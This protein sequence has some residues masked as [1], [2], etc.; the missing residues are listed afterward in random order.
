MANL[1]PCYLQISNSLCT[2][3]WYAGKG[4]RFYHGGWKTASSRKKV[5]QPIESRVGWCGRCVVKCCSTSS[6]TSAAEATEQVFLEDRSS[7][8]EKEEQ[9]EYLASE[10]GWKVRRLAENRDE[11]SEVAQIQAEAFHTPV[12]LFD[13]VFFE[14]FKAEVLSGLLY[15]LRNSS[16]RQVKP[17][18]QELII[19]DGE[20]LLRRD[21]KPE[22]VKSIFGI[23]ACLVAE[24]AAE[25]KLVGIVDVTALRDEDVLQHLEGADEYLYISGI[26]VSNNFR[27]RKIG[28]ALLKACDTLSHLWGFECLALRAYEDDMGARKLYTNAGYRVVSSDPRWMAWIGRKRRVLMIKRSNMLD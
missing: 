18:N 17:L 13:D 16:P 15:K 25:R 8:D 2:E 21:F 9:F 4:S 22:N 1:R 19:C 7:V 28:S 6:P 26:A 10:S 3:P 23:Y 11:M 5:S 27:R 20:T 12:A 14:F 24:P